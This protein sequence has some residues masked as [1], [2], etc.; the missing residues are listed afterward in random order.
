MTRPRRKITLQLV[1]LLD[2]MLVILFLQFMELDERAEQAVSAVAQER[3]ALSAQR[4]EAEQLVEKA[5]DQ[6][7][8]VGQLAYELFNLPD[9]IGRAHV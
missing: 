5:F 8:L 9:E 6:R 2:L 7:D 4:R 1:P 3:R